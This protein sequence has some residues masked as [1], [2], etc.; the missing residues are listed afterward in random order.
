MWC[1][2]MAL[3][4]SVSYSCQKED[5]KSDDEK[6]GPTYENGHEYVDLGLSVKWAT[7]NVGASKPEDYGDYFAWGDTT[8]YYEP[9]YAQSASPV[10]KST[11][12]EGYDWASYRYCKNVYGYSYE[13]IKY[14]N[15]GDYGYDYFTDTLTILIPED[16]VAHV[17]WGG[18]WRMPTKSDFEELKAKCDWQKTTQNGVAGW[19]VTSRKDSSRFIF[20]PTAGYRDCTRLNSVGSFGG[21]WSSSLA[22][23]TPYNA[24]GLNL[25][26]Y[27]NVDYSSRTN[28][29]SV[30]PVCP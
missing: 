19:R 26:I 1:L 6:K 9:G 29:Q 13:M 4:M 12:S 5:V 11:C 21:Y 14:C 25:S 10:W 15:I 23:S 7:C 24:Y 3:L 30:R 17:K 16:D 8:T 20:L 22:T 18:S 28:G 2:S 27:E